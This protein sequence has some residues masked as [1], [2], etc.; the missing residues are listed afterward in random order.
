MDKK[1]SDVS[2]MFILLNSEINHLVVVELISF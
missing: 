2:L 1:A